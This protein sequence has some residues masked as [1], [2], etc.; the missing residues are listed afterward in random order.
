MQK[1]KRKKKEGKKERK[2][3]ETHLNFKPGSV[4]SIINRSPFEVQMANL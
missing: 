2:K 3:K 1:K 4:T